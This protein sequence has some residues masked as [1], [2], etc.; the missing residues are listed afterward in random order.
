MSSEA[1]IIQRLLKA[2][3]AINYWAKQ[4]LQANEALTKAIKK[5]STKQKSIEE[6]GQVDDQR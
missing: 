6:G 3:Q 5:Q 1:K 2:V 4:F